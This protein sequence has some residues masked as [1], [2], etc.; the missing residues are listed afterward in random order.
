MGPWV[1][2]MVEV[3][4]PGGRP[5]A[6]GV[7]G[8]LGRRA[9]ADA[10]AALGRAPAVGASTDAASRRRVAAR[11]APGPRNGRGPIRGRSP[12][13]RGRPGRSA[14][15]ARRGPAPPAPRA[16]GEAEERE[17]GASWVQVTPQR[18]APHRAEHPRAAAHRRLRRPRP[19]DPHLARTSCPTRPVL[20]ALTSAAARGVD[21]TLIIPERLDSRLAQFAG[22]AHLADLRRGER[23]RAPPPR[24][25]AA[26]QERDRR[27]RPV[28][29]RHRQPRRA[30]L[31]PE[32]R[33]LAAGLRPRLHRRARSAAARLPRPQPAGDARPSSRGPASRE[34]SH[35]T[36]RG[37]SVRCSE[38]E[39]SAPLI[40]PVIEKQR[41]S[42][43]A[44]EATL[45]KGRASLDRHPSFRAPLAALRPAHSA[46]PDCPL[47]WVSCVRTFTRTSSP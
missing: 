17:R 26:H 34:G 12:P 8:G 30:Q 31:L 13:R 46:C 29:R 33:A 5:A 9:P 39:T 27:R 28:H 18:P 36:R 7:P 2:V 37:T 20:V 22:E 4:G 6:R 32:L 38:A 25:A 14:A 40:E 41:R 35:A 11:P 16:L 43:V 42:S 21:V 23:R 44:G 45:R 15:P 3:A 47:T 10:A 1:D 19:G 24:R